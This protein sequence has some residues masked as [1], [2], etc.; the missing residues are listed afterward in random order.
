MAGAWQQSSSRMMVARGWLDEQQM[1]RQTGCT[2]SP[3]VSSWFI[4]LQETHDVAPLLWVAAVKEQRRTEL[5]G[6]MCVCACVFF[7]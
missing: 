6:P 2:E 3:L 5:R 7:F 4:R 1:W